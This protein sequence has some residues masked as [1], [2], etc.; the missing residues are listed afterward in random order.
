MQTGAATMEYSM[1]VLQNIEIKLW[2]NLTIP[3]LGIYPKTLTGKDICIPMFTSNSEGKESA[4]NARDLGSNPR[5]KEPLEKGMV[6]HSNI[7]SWRIPQRKKPGG[8]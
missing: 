8:L 7:L 1:N 3:L 5:L 4:C 6:T 2:Y